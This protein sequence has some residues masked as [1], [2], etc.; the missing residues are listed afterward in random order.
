MSHLNGPTKFRGILWLA[1]SSFRWVAFLCLLNALA[2]TQAR[3]QDIHGLYHNRWTV[4]DGSPR[5]ITAIA[6]D[7]DGLLWLGS[8]DGLYRFDGV[9]FETY[10][11][12][13]APAESPFHDIGVLKTT[14][15]GLWIG[16]VTGGVS[17]LSRGHLTTYGE[18][19]G[20]APGE[21]HS[22]TQV[23][24]GSVWVATDYGLSRF[25]GRRWL[26]GGFKTAYP[27]SHPNE[28]FFDSRG[29]LWASTATGLFF[30]PKNQAKFVLAD[31]HVTQ[32]A[33]FSE[34]SDGRVWFASRPLGV[35]AI[36]DER[37]AYASHG[38]GVDY[39]S[40]GVLLDRRGALWITTVGQGLIRAEASSLIGSPRRT[41][42][43]VDIL[44]ERDG[45]T[46]DFTHQAIED[47][48]GSVWVTSDKG[49]DQFRRPRFT[50]IRLPPESE[51]VGIAIDHSGQL[52][53]GSKRVSRVTDRRST[54]LEK[55]PNNIGC[56]YADTDGTVWLNSRD[57]LWSL[58]GL[59]IKQHALPPTVHGDSRSVQTMTM[60]KEHRLWV[61]FVGVGLYELSRGKW[62]QPDL[63]SGLP[64]GPP[65]IAFTASDGTMWFGYPN[66]QVA[67]IYERR[68]RTYGPADGVNVGTVIALQEIEGHLWI[69]GTKGLEY[70]KDG[71]F[72]H[73]TLA[74]LPLSGVS[75]I[76]RSPD[77]SIW[78]NTTEGI[79]R[80]NGAEIDHLLR[81][82]EQPIAA[83][84]F[85]Y[86][87]GITGEPEQ[88]RPL[89]TVVH[90]A[91]GRLFFTTRANVI[92]IDPAHI[93]KNS[94]PPVVTVRSLTTGGKTFL[95]PSEVTLPVHSQDVVINYSASSLLIPERVHFRYRLEGADKT[96]Q[97]V[98][99]RRQ[100][101]FAKLPPGTYTFH[102]KASNDDGVWSETGAQVRFF[103][104]PK[105]TQRT[106]FWI[107]CVCVLAGFLWLAYWLRIQTV[108]R[109]IRKRL[110][111]RIR[112]REDIARDLH[113]TFLQSVQGL[114]LSF[115]TGA[116]MISGNHPS[117][118]VLDDA[119][120]NSDRVLHEGRNIVTQLRSRV[121]EHNELS[122]DLISAEA[123]L[124]NGST[125]QFRLK[126]TGTPCE[127]P[128]V[129]RE[130]LCQIGRE[131]MCN[132]FRHANATSLHI[133]LNYGPKDFILEITDDGI[134]IDQA[135]L[136]AGGRPNHW[137]LP[138][139]QER[140]KRIGATFDI[141]AGPSI[142]TSIEVCLPGRFAYSKAAPTKPS[143][144]RRLGMSLRDISHG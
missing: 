5:Y 138:G 54:T 97:D 16:Y 94:L 7:V 32:N 24:G 120:Q 144:V 14:P 118:K 52:V 22:I 116:S 78:L 98:G 106:S 12:P 2:V 134:G 85:T 25:D 20:L 119:L 136:A 141:K 73:V 72:Q 43:P 77:R 111:E 49:L 108:E 19:D 35:R 23:P 31:S 40:S 133:A 18:K 96:W 122:N 15:E 8:D 126:I 93:Y 80:L 99:T 38:A 75:G 51:F 44:T 95:E 42:P 56:V 4:R 41:L 67:T 83:D 28:I 110:I 59:D 131:A 100:V 143:L 62:S 65:L 66:N 125:I 117:R 142:G 64:N 81:K 105:I 57:G 91:D 139:M 33:D 30:L 88:V 140:A 113:D 128:S 86:L 115:H 70:L 132:A 102:V 104:A 87:D 101:S 76:A 17:L 79:F 3:C 46:G 58:S 55:G 92:W 69:G 11:L 34:G 21:V 84:Q 137:G 130:D 10:R 63:A 68:T 37:G 121:S 48:E 123:E 27:R 53:I 114:V 90:R 6:S 109:K 61:S 124:R 39:A 13:S 103:I 74:G 29:T 60:D 9:A 82:P 135:V 1:T 89:P 47:R 50:P 71:R 129:I 26:D 107:L 45:L 112:E 36:T 127:L